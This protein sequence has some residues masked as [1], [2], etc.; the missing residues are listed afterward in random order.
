LFQE[1]GERALEQPLS[2]GLGGLLQGEQIGV[3]GRT[4]IAEG[5]AGNDFAPLGGKVTE[6]LEFLGG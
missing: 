3:Q 4:G 2:G 1:G 5:A 6:I